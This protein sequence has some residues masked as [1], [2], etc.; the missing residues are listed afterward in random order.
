MNTFNQTGELFLLV[1][2]HYYD[3]RLV[4]LSLV[5]NDPSLKSR[6]GIQMDSWKVVILFCILKTKYICPSLA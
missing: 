1:S 5:M 4:T 6:G 2:L 3:T